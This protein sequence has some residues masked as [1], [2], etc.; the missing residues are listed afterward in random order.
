VDCY[1]ETCAKTV[2]TENCASLGFLG[3]MRF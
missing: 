3:F 2:K 1:E